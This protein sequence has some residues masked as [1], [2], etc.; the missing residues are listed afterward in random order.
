MTSTHALSIPRRRLVAGVL[1]AVGGWMTR[2]LPLAAQTPTP[3]ACD[4]AAP[5]PPTPAQ[6]AGPYFTPGSPERANFREEGM[7]GTPLSLTGQVVDGACGPLAETKIDV[8]HADAEGRY[9]N[10]G[11]RLRGHLFTHADGAYMLE[12]IVPGLYPGRTR[13]IHVRLTTADGRELT[14]QLYFPDEPENAADPIYDPRLEI[15]PLESTA[16]GERAGF[17]FVIP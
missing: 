6:L 7:A 16:D 1:V 8:W 13:H 5:L 15:T 14:T 12:T 4:P 10:E 11:F 17:T 3:P 9:D 2:S